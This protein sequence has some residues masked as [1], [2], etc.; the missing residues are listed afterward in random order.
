MTPSTSTGLLL[1]VLAAAITL[2]LPAARTG[3]APQRTVA[4]LSPEFMGM[5]VRDPYY[6]YDTYPGL[7]GPNT[8]AQD[9][10]GRQLAHIGVRWVRL[11]F[12]ADPDGRVNF[13]KYDYF[14]G[15]VA[16]RYG[17]KVL[18]VLAT[19]IIRDNPTTL[20]TGTTGSDPRYGGG[21]NEYMVHWLD[22]ALA[23][24][25][26]YNGGPYGRVHAFEMFNE[27][28]RLFGD[29]TN[30]PDG[31][32]Y[33]GLN[34][35][36]VARLHAKFY[37]ICKNTDGSQPGASCPAD[38]RVILGGLHPKGT[39]AKRKPNE[40]EKIV[41][42]DE[43]YLQ[44]M[45]Q[46]AFTDF[47]NYA[48]NLDPWRGQWPVEGI[49]FHPYPEEIEPRPQTIKTVSEDMYLKILPRLDQMRA[50][51]IAVGDP[52]QLFWITEVGYNVGSY[53][54]RGPLAETNLNE[55]ML[56]V[57]TLLAARGDVANIFWFK[58]EDFP[59]ANVVYD[60]KGKPIQDPQQ[61]GVVHIPFTEGGSVNGVPCA[62]GAC[63]APTG[64]PSYTR[65]SYI[66]YR[67]L[68]GLPVEQTFIPLVNK[69]G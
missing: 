42:T 37:R 32:D 24:A 8:I 68:A 21:V 47:K 1:I 41:Y 53:Q 58:Y 15:Q 22:A 12:I 9:E 55:F 52:Y 7:R 56:Q 62:G 63:Y 35:A 36:Y 49:G 23:I 10:M 27:A 34:P 19:Q 60:S 57:Y 65:A 51:L 54:A 13:D 45:Y 66:T 4:P 61:W 59:P 64:Q 44:I 6:D 33:A 40:P 29:G 67:M 11:E 5:A 26:R 18:G 48:N 25:T 46:S 17:F 2:A 38:T 28:N 30:L 39:S 20:N 50:M 43:Q 14:I 31:V 69:Q 3:A 16:P